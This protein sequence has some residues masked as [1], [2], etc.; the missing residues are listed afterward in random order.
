MPSPL[1]KSEQA[2]RSRARILSA[3]RVRFA[4]QGF[5]AT[6]VRAV[7]GDASIDASM[8]IRY[9]GSKAGLF[10]SATAVDLGLADFAHVPREELGATIAAHFFDLWEE[11]GTGDP[12]RVLLASALRDTAAAERIRS[13]FLDQLL[14]SIHRLAPEEADSADTRAA[15]I[16]A[17]LLGFALCRYVVRLDPIVSLDRVGAVE[18]LGPAVQGHLDGVHVDS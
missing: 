13:V 17:Q 15:L 14:P 5:E 6:T 2:A 3:A 11:G 4:E 7:A 12:L 16:A 8:V 10:A 1:P 9:F 18:W